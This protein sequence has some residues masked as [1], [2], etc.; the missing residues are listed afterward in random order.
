VSPSADRRRY[1]LWRTLGYLLERLPVDFAV[2]VAERIGWAASFVGTGGR[3]A[4]RSNVRRIIEHGSSV[5]V[6]ERVLDRWVRRSFASYGRYW[7][8]GATLPVQSGARV[9]ERIK[10]V[11]GSDHLDQAMAAGRG[12]IIALPHI[13]S[14][15]WGGAMLAQMGYPMTAIAEEL[16]PPELFDYFVAK[17]EQMGLHIEAL[18]PE[19]G[20]TVMGVLREG[21]LVGLLC[22]RDIEG[23]GVDVE[24]LG[25]KTTMPAGP[26]TLA[27]R[28]G[29]ALLVAVIYSGPGHHHV[30]LISA[31]VTFERQGR[32]REDVQMLTQK[33]ADQLSGFIRRAPEQWHVFSDPFSPTEPDS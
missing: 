10:I 17:R 19:A 6:D 20:R 8:E 5:P 14:W 22:D 21:G 2:A 9:L 16:E 28:T 26:A 23:T 30:A 32:L 33:V 18:G 25:T 15:E 24:L 7:A 31:P 29:A 4:A 11:E 27:L 1:L 12:C 3:D 13:G